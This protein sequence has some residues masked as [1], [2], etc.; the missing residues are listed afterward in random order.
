MTMERGSRMLS[1]SWW[2]FDRYLIDERET[3]RPAPE[4][5]GEDYDVWDAFE[6]SRGGRLKVRPEQQPARPTRPAAGQSGRRRIELPY[7]ELVS[8]A[9]EYMRAYTA[10]KRS[11]GRPRETE[12]RLLAWCAE[13]GPLGLLPHQLVAARFPSA[14]RRPDPKRGTVLDWM[15]G[16]FWFDKKPWPNNLVN[17]LP[18]GT[19]WRPLNG[20]DLESHPFEVYW[21]RHFPVGSELRSPHGDALD[22]YFT[23]VGPEGNPRLPNEH[24]W[25][26]YGEPLSD[27]VEAGELLGGALE[28]FREARELREAGDSAG[29]EQSEAFGSSLLVTMTCVATPV[30]RHT[31]EG[32]LT[33]AWGT[34]SLLSNLAIMAMSDLV[35]GARLIS[36][37][38]CGVTAVTRSP[39]GKYCSARCRERGPR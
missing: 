2:R 24:F 29:A 33:F 12:K 9:A 15:P 7:Q 36:C 19:V 38:S 10:P 3:I 18:Y 14:G 30:L 23:A 27:F 8:I 5:V 31:R 35:G 28:A 4:A 16:G 20:G 1:S 39:N 32:R 34:P 6:Q 13:N 21:A 22:G 37:A 17:Q 11:P 25:R 26:A